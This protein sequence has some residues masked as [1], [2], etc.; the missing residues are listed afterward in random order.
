MGLLFKKGAPSAFPGPRISGCAP[1]PRPGSAR[2][3]GAGPGLL[4]PRGWH[5]RRGLCQEPG[6]YPCLSPL[7]Q[8]R[9]QR[10]PSPARRSPWEDPAPTPLTKHQAPVCAAARRREDK[11]RREGPPRAVGGTE[12][13]PP[14]GGWTASGSGRAAAGAAPGAGRPG[15]PISAAVG[16]GAQGGVAFPWR[17]TWGFARQGSAGWREEMKRGSE[18]ETKRMKKSQRGKAQND[19]PRDSQEKERNCAVLAFK[20]V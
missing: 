2:V 9:F 8:L 17:G 18:T 19:G 12:E 4:F 15:L 13:V 10:G 5:S 6:G 3:C 7:P 14:G 20:H 11:I 16:W 1:R